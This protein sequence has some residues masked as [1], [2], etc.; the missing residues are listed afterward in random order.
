MTVVYTG[1]R[2]WAYGL[3]PEWSPEAQDMFFKLEWPDTLVQM[4]IR[5]ETMEI[6]AADLDELVAQVTRREIPLCNMESWRT[7]QSPTSGRPKR[8]P[9][10][11]PSRYLSTKGLPQRVSRWTGPH[12]EALKKSWDPNITHLG[13]NFMETDEVYYYVVEV[14]WK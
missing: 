2:N 13:T 10:P 11:P 5:L 8:V 9:T 3:E 14:T 4:C 6:F 1:C 12:S 7:F